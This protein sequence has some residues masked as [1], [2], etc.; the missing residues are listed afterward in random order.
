MKNVLLSLM[1]L[2]V[3]T[4]CQHN[5]TPFTNTKSSLDPI[6]SLFF[7]TAPKILQK[8]NTK[9]ISF[10]KVTPN[11]SVDAGI[12]LA[13][14]PWKQEFILEA[15]EEGVKIGET[16]A[17]CDSPL[18]ISFVKESDK[19]FRLTVTIIPKLEK[20]DFKCQVTIPVIEPQGA[21]NLDLLI[22]GKVR[23]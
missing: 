10:L 7:T 14:N 20:P 6:E 23:I 13:E 16:V 18:K 4:S 2:I 1:L 12:V 9:T 22:T 11:A 17:K 3:F 21:K 8:S 15:S 19:L 5:T